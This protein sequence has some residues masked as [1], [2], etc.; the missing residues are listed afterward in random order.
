M[1]SHFGSKSG[2]GKI[3]KRQILRIVGIAAI[4][5][6][7]VLPLAT[8]AQAASTG[9]LSGNTVTTVVDLQITIS[10]NAFSIGGFSFAGHLGTKTKNSDTGST[11]SRTWS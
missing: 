6:G 9:I 5:A 4:A 2:R 1:A 8:P 3:V 7:G 11:Q 10:G